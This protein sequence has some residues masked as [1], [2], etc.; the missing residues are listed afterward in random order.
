LPQISS[1]VI[2][3]LEKIFPVLASIFQFLWID[4]H[5]KVGSVEAFVPKTLVNAQRKEHESFKAPFVPLCFVPLMSFVAVKPEILNIALADD[6]E[7]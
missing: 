2:Y 7:I 4:A 6:D 1:I 5:A 3:H